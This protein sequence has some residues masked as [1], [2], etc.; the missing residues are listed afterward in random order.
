MDNEKILSTDIFINIDNNLT[1]SKTTNLFHQYRRLVMY[2]TGAELSAKF[3][4]N[5]FSKRTIG[6]S[7][8]DSQV[9]LDSFYKDE[10]D[11]KKTSTL[12]KSNMF[13]RL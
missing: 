7:R 5:F 11:L 9:T 1:I 13:N 10:I 8:E 2:S 6:I 12:L 4:D 3:L